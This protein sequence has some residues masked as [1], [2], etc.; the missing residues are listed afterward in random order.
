MEDKIH[1]ARLKKGKDIFEVVVNPDAAMDFRQGKAVLE[2]ALVSDKVYFDA[3]KALVASEE[4]LKNLFSTEN[5][6]D[7]AKEII[8]RGD[9][10]LSAEYREKKRLELRKQI[11]NFISS[12]AIDPGTNL[13]HPPTRIES[14]IEQARVKIDENKNINEQID[15]IIKKLKPVIPI[16]IVTKEILIKVPSQHTKVYGQLLKLGKVLRE[17]WGNDGALMLTVE[18]PGGLEVSIYEKI[19]KLTQGEADV[20]VI[21]TK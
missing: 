11:I 20:K 2:D 19:N 16:K 18:I 15:D 10:Q 6:H 12:Y 9:I 17:E 3:K 7:I 14:A 13:P 4:K 5:F 8:L 21:K 1:L